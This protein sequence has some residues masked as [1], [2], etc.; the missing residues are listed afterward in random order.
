MKLYLYLL[1][2]HTPPLSHCP[3]PPPLPL[4]HSPTVPL[5]HCPTVPPLL[6]PSITSIL[7]RCLHG[8][9]LF[10]PVPTTLGLSRGLSPVILVRDGTR[11][12]HSLMATTTPLTFLMPA[13]MMLLTTAGILM[14]L[15]VPGATPQI[16]SRDGSTAL[17][18]NVH[19]NYSVIK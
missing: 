15:T 1:S 17:Y 13:S 2:L 7:S 5:P 12:F 6:L 9:F 8:P 10:Q 19:C 16:Y 11:S 18:Q 4:S 3:T 14:A